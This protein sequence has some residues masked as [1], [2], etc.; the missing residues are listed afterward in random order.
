M[1][2]ESQRDRGRSPD[3]RPPQLPRRSVADRHDDTTRVRPVMTEHLTRDIPG[4]HPDPH[5]A[6]TF[7][8]PPGACD[9]HCHVFGPAD[10]FPFAPDRAYTPPDASV[11][12][13]EQG[14]D[15]AVAGRYCAAFRARRR[16]PDPQPDR[17]EPAAA[18]S[19]L[20]RNGSAMAVFGGSGGVTRRLV[21]RFPWSAWS[22]GPGSNR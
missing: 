17:L 20:R 14:H 7:E 19:L 15:P 11:D 8:P 1:R 21:E 13:V 16:A 12:D 6:T 2:G 5:P 18:A 10:R 4:P 3:Q 9:A 22:P